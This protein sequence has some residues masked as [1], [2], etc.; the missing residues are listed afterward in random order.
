MKVKSGDDVTLQCR[1]PGEAA[2]RLLEWIRPDLKSVGYVFFYRDG[3]IHGDSQH[4]LFHGR[5]ELKDKKMKDGDV[6]VVL[7]NIN[8][9]DT[10]RYECH[11]GITG[12]SRK[13]I[14]TINM[15][16]V[17]PGNNREDGGDKDGGYKN[18]GDKNGHVGLVAGLSVAV[19]FF[20][21]IGFIIYKKR[22]KLIL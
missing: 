19:L 11:V 5:V 15:T 14:N 8:I 20:S 10:G 9:N 6:S 17:E 1:D 3:H 7:K 22:H 2:I 16:V 12:S 13:V 4:P 18:G 21:F